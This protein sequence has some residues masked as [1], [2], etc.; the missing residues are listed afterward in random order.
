MIDFLTEA[1]KLFPYTQSMRR[2]FHMHPELGHQ[3]IRTAGVVARELKSLGLEVTTG[4]G[5]TGVVAMIEGAK[6]GPV[7]LLRAD[8]DA[9]PIHEET[10][11][12]YA[13][14]TPGVMHACGHDAH[15]A[16]L[17]TVAKLLHSIR[18]ELPGSVKLV[19]QPAEE[20]MG[21]AEGMIADG[22]LEN[23]KVDATL[24]LHIWNEQPLG[25]L[26]LAAGPVMAGT[27]G[28]Q[29]RI[30]GKGGHG[31]IPHL[32]VD[33]ILA[34][35]HVVSALQ[36]IVSRNTPPLQAAVVSVTTFHGGEAFNVIPPHVEL[37]GTIRTFDLSVRAMVL[38]RFDEIVQG[39]VSG[40]GC[41]AEIEHIRMTPAL[42][43]DP[44]A[45]RAAQ[46]AAQRIL[47][48]SHIETSG[49][50]T[51]GGEDFAF[52][53]EQVPGMFLFVGSANHEKGLSYGHHHP[54]F[55]F[56]E[57]VLPRAA[58]LLAA[59]TLELMENRTG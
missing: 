35:A 30:R 49:P 50:F 15:T 32:A 47:P 42:I 26:G 25:W 21:G 2:D 14:R 34:G 22:V 54:K 19:F 43:N 31:A 57:A 53:M 18:Q 3:E 28:F 29:I 5:K 24:G 58:A 8:M 10:G 45:A 36:S 55:D 20:G 13:S 56:D 52:M 1:Q 16:I 7:I 48:E 33:P 41:E 38:R 40:M 39:V 17:L 44:Q 46:R 27:E 11:A 6:P 12:E 37:S 59:T 51:M 9:L 4:V 23:P